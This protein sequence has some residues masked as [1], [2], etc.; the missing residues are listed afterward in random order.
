MGG[1]RV[2]VNNGPPAK[3][4]NLSS[5]PLKSFNW[6]KIPPTKTKDTIWEELDDSEIHKKLKKTTA[7]NDFEELFAAKE[8]KVI[9]AVSAEKLD[10]GNKEITFL[11]GKRSQNV[12]IMLKAIKLE[13]TSIKKAILTC[14]LIILPRFVLTELFKLIPTDDEINTVKQYEKDLK[15]LANAE[16]FIYEISEISKYEQKLKAMYFKASFSEYQE[17]AE[18]MINALQAGSTDILRGGKFKELLKVILA[19]GNYMNSG[20]RGGAYGFKIGS[21]LKVKYG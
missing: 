16:R 8:T 21:I 5:K 4:T 10:Q 3:P 19:L 18:T 14:N 12:N 6:Q 9:E 20:Q 17:D 15:R 11:D 7:Y 1:M 13:P 2:P